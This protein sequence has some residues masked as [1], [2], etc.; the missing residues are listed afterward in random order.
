MAVAE[1]RK[2]RLQEYLAAEVNVKHADVLILVCCLSSGMVDSTLYSAYDTFVSMQT[3]NTIFL[4]LGASNQ[5]S[6]PY[7]WAHCLTSIATFIVG[8]F[9]FSRLNQ[10]FGARRRGTLVASFFIQSVLILVTAGIITGGVIQGIARPTE[11]TPTGTM[12]YSPQWSQEAPIV[13]LSFQAAG[14]IVTSRALGFNEVPTVVITSLLCDLMSDPKLFVKHNVKRNRRIVGFTL[15]LVGAI[16]AGWIT[17]ASGN[18]YAVLWIVG[19]F[20]MGIAVAWGVWKSLPLSP[21]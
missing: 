20:K 6:R 5:N 12:E 4:G 11:I 15:T 3:G 7:G 17:K 13:L 21:V 9:F 8:C 19:G 18:I 2:A 16:A 14:Q 10:F 1:K